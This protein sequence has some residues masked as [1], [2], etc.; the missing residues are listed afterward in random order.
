MLISALSRNAPSAVS[1]TV[2]AGVVAILLSA[3]SLQWPLS[4]PLALLAAF[5]PFG[6]RCG[7]A[8]AAG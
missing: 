7:S 6:D 5:N 4:T 1:A 2:L 3:V 8:E